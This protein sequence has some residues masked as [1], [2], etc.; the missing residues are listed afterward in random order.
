SGHIEPPGAQSLFVSQAGQRDRDLYRVAFVI[1]PACRQP[2][3]V[4]GQIHELAFVRNQ[5]VLLRAE[6]I[7]SETVG[8]ATVMTGVEQNLDLIV[9]GESRVARQLTRVDLARLR[10]KGAYTEIDV[11]LVKKDSNFGLF[12]CGRAF[13]RTLHAKASGDLRLRP[14]WFVQTAINFDRLRCTYR[15][16]SRTFS[17]RWRL[18]K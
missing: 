18:P 11:L 1:N 13:L 15:P 9:I 5:C 8:V 2:C 16:Y 12:R 3:C 14:G 17:G 7:D 6:R 10:I 4:P